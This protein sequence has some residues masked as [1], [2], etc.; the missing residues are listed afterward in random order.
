MSA[1]RRSRVTCS[2]RPRIELSPAAWYS[3]PGSR[4]SG[5]KRRTRCTLA[6][7]GAHVKPRHLPHC[8]PVSAASAAVTRSSA[9]SVGTDLHQRSVIG[10]RSLPR[11]GGSSRQPWGCATSAVIVSS[12]CDDPPKSGRARVVSGSRCLFHAALGREAPRR[13]RSHA[14]PLMH[15]APAS[16]LLIEER[17]PSA[18]G[19]SKPKSRRGHI[20][21]SVVR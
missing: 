13:P 11:S 16:V 18:D 15:V 21:R 8:R 7:F 14:Y 3:L 10:G 17:L 2:G 5:R 12:A 19:W 4:A 9:V 1:G 20:Q 6:V